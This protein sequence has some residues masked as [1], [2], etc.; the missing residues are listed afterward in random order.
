MSCLMMNMFAKCSCGGGMVCVYCMQL[1]V[2]VCAIV[3]G[4]LIAWKPKKTIDTQI[5]I[6]RKINWKME[7]VSM[8]K[9]MRNTQIMGLTV[10][11]FG[12]ISLVYF[13]LS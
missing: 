2:A 13:M 11:I 12:V 6:Y 8:K 3:F 4:A 9:E 7:P 5:A 1:T 10:L